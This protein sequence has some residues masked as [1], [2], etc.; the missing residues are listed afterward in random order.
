MRHSPVCSSFI[1]NFATMFAVM[2]GN[3][4]PEQMKNQAGPTTH[5]IRCQLS[6]HNQRQPTAWGN[7]APLKERA[8]ICCAEWGCCCTLAE[9]CNT[10][11]LHCL[12]QQAQNSN[13]SCSTPNQPS[14]QNAWAHSLLRGAY[15]QHTDSWLLPICARS[16]IQQHTVTLDE[17]V[18][19]SH[20]CPPCL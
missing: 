12:H 13:S 19:Y 4:P 11:G 2:A 5:F 15:I 17:W 3:C 10:D 7:M 16:H 1:L 8:W 6:L 20:W 14:P 18:P 9:V